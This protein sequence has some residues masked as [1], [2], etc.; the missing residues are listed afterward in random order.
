MVGIR[1]NENLKADSRTNQNICGVATQIVR[2][3]LS[4][5]AVK[6]LQGV[7]ISRP[8]HPFYLCSQ[9]ASEREKSAIIIKQSSNQRKEARQFFSSVASPAP[10]CVCL[11][12]G[13]LVV[14]VRYSVGGFFFFYL[15]E[16]GSIIGVITKKDDM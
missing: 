5:S 12:L 9:K 7:L 2:Y 4:G 13:F 10:I 11:D 15:P 6:V 1:S 14:S 8:A 3:W 16:Y